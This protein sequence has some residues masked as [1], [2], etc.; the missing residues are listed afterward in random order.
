VAIEGMEPGS[1][2]IISKLELTCPVNYLT[3]GTGLSPGDPKAY[4]DP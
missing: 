3:D 1:K 2:C 4:F